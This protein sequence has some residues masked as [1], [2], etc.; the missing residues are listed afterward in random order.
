[1]ERDVSPLSSVIVTEPG[2]IL[3]PYNFCGID[4]TDA[5]VCKNLYCLP[6]LAPKF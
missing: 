1:M 3:S 6:S 2:F 5:D 4:I